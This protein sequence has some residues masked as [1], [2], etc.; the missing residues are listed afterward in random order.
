MFQRIRA[1]VVALALGAGALAMA[2]PAT[3]AQ[4]ALAPPT[5]ESVSVSPSPVEVTSG[6]PVAVTF[7]AVT[8][9]DATKVTG[10]LKPRIGVET[11]FE[12]TKTTDDV[13]AGKVK[14]AAKRD[15]GRAFGT[16]KWT[17]RALA[18]K[19]DE[20]SA[21]KST[22]FVVK[23]VFATRIVDF[24][25]DPDLVDKGATVVLSGRLQI[26][27]NGWRGLG[28]EKVAITFRPKHG[29]TYRHV[30]TIQTG[31]HGSFAVGLQ[32]HETGWWRAE[33][34]G[35]AQTHPTVSDT[36]RVDV[37]VPLKETRI[38]DFAVPAKVDKG[39]ALAWQGR[40][41]LEDRH[42][43][44][45]HSGQ[46]VLI[47]FQTDGSSTWQHVATSWTD[48]Q[49]RFSGKVEAKASGKWKAVYEGASGVKGT[50][51]DEK[52]VKVVDP[53][54]PP[55]PEKVDSR[56]IKFNAYPEPVRY[57]RYLK[58]RGVLQIDD[59]FGWRGH[60]AE[61]GLYFKAKGTK[62]W[63]FVKTTWSTGSGKLYTRVQATKSG[64]WRFYFRG[65]GD[66]YKSYS[67]SDYVRIIKKAKR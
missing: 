54:P 26:D 66:S 43:W 35:T 31:R 7:S 21:P 56:L 63:K 51:S 3:A 44:R 62:S 53:T 60:R 2:P 40:L 64:Y 16:Q 48:G 4:G 39:D 65:D 10:W 30:A 11:Q 9:D 45:G 42:G 55:P 58:F 59:E 1:V 29:D 19:G 34:A 38:I 14:W 23:Q 41:L 50:A 22:E 46:K 24:D 17:F 6:S 36:D 37:K 52:Y 15:V 5:L 28:G 8:S 32:V 25:A 67:K 33:Y 61:V 13:G 57:G 49:G 27:K 12:L 20:Q 47:V 18:A